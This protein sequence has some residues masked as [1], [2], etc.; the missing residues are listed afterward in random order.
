MEYSIVRILFLS[1]YFRPDLSAGSF[2]AAMLAD[3]LLD[4]LPPGSVID[5]L[6]T[7]PNR[8][9]SFA[10]EALATETIGNL[11]ITRIALPP[12]KNGMRD[13]SRAFLSYAREAL[14]HTAEK[15]YDLVFA[16]SSRLMTASLG[17]WFARRKRVPLYLDIRDIFVDTMKDI[18]P[19][20]VALSAR[21][22]LSILERLTVR[23]A[24]RTNLVSA[25]FQEYFA[26]RYPDMPLSFFTNGI[27]DE[28][29]NLKPV[30]KTECA[31]SSVVEILY[32]GNLGDGQGMD[33]ILPKLALRL[34]DRA[35]FR[36]IGD[37]GRRRALVQALE[38]SGVNNVELLPLVSR[39]DLV[40]A[41][42]R[43]DV[44]FLHLNTHEAFKKVLPSKI[45]EYGAS[46]KPILAGIDGYAASFVRSE[47]SNAA[48]FPP[49]DAEA[50]EHAFGSLSLCWSDRSA[51]IRQYSRKKIMQEM[52]QDVIGVVNAEA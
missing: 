26:S 45:F 33:V 51:F 25:G 32:A 13:Q 18:L 39:K 4:A 52:A 43:C 2:R 37:G 9:G 35:R 42:Q 8:Y 12:H 31:D 17:A 49:S 29:L 6:T 7:L 48:V 24:S 19:R 47:L 36:V 15:N 3:A 41:Y 44:L 30:E 27:D 46:G 40:A 21:P 10:T 16:T 22:V 20:P 50:G 34:A 11:R 1:F 5:V 28:F 23:Q 14:K 38:E